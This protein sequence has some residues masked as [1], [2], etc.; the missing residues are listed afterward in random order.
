MD[1]RELSVVDGKTNA[2]R[3]GVA[4]AYLAWGLE[5]TLYYL[6]VGDPRAIGIRERCDLLRRQAAEF[7]RPTSDGHAKRIG[8]D[9]NQRALLLDVI[10]PEHPRNPFQRTVRFRNWLL[11]TML[12][13]FGFRRS[14]SL[15]LYV[16]DVNVSGRRPHITVRRRPDDPND[17]R[18]N[19]PAVKTLGREIPLDPTMADVLNR[20]LQYHRPRFPNADKCPFMF[21]GNRKAALTAVGQRRARTGRPTLSR[22]R[23]PADAARVALHV[24][25]HVRRDGADHWNRRR[26]AQSCAELH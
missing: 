7:Q 15:K 23:R 13:T 8:L 14:E 24:Q 26:S 3:V 6:D 2:V 25:R 22:V 9:A 18:A 17:P 19:E 4:R 12:L 16:G 1:A 21:L 5:R 10:H 11:I 20:Y